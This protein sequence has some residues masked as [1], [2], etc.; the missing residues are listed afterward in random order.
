MGRKRRKSD[1]PPADLPMTPM[2]DVVFQLLIFFIVTIKPIDVFA[3]LDVNR[4][5]P[6]SRQEK[7][8]TPK[9]I[10]IEVHEEGFKVNDRVLSREKLEEF[11]K[12][13]GDL[14]PTQT[15]LIMCSGFAHHEQLVDVLDTCA[16]YKLSNLSVVSTN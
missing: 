2:I 9:L 8:E 16:K 5:S 11:L 1:M 10:R 12:S 7:M 3:N 14:D 6:D 13:A 4:P 15:I